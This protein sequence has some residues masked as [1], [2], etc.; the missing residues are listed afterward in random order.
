[1]AIYTF[2]HDIFLMRYYSVYKGIYAGGIFIQSLIPIF[3]NV[4]VKQEIFM[5]DVTT[6]FNS[7]KRVVQ[8]FQS[9]AHADAQLQM[10][11]PTVR[12]VSFDLAK[13][14]ILIMRL[15]LPR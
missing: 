13:S 10:A 3:I 12:S 6:C 5:S 9:A 8:E 4:A 1:M 15:G 11:Q 14:N 7:L 2:M